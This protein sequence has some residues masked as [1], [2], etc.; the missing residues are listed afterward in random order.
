MMIHHC[1]AVARGTT[2]PLLIADMPYGSFQ[3]SEE[4]TVKNAIRLVREG[5]VEGVKLEGG[6]EMTSRVRALTSVGIPVLGHVGLLP[7]RHVALSGY[8]VQGKNAED[9]REV[10][11]NA[12]ALEQAGVFGIVLESVPWRLASYVTAKLSVP[13]IGIGA[14]PGTSGQVLASPSTVLSFN[15]IYMIDHV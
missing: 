9:A 13:T 7:Q 10:L 5:G 8:R 6:S 4:D 1:A 15:V 11:R 14:G 12:V 3:V 2:T